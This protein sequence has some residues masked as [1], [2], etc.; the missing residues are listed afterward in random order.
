LRFREDGEG[1]VDEAATGPAATA[2]EPD[3]GS[4]DAACRA[5]DLVILD[6]EDMSEVDRNG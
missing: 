4:E 3:V 6:E 5:A 2:D 1:R